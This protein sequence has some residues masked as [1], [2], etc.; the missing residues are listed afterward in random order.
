MNIIFCPLQLKFKS[1][2]VECPFCHSKQCSKHGY[3]HRKGFH[4]KN[5]C[6]VIPKAIP[7]FRC[8][9]PQCKHSTFSLL[10]AMVLRYCRFFWPCL[11]MIWDAIAR[12]LTPYQIA[13]TWGVD[14]AVIVRAAA[15][16]Y[17]IQPFAGKLHQELSNGSTDQ[18]QSKNHTLSFLVRYIARKIGIVALMNR[19][20][21]HRYPR[22][23]LTFKGTT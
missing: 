19:W 5:T 4:L 12:G 13:K 2:D 17:T 23:Y 21:C 22:R 16:Q 8:N 9:N 1:F 11:Q 15:L 18:I 7:R 3:Y 14:R 6:L 10:P 20:Y